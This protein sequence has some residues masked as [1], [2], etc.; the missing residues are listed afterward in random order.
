MCSYYCILS[1]DIFQIKA[2]EF[3]SSKPSIISGVTNREIK[4]KIF[5]IAEIDT[6]SFLCK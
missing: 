5:H 1:R 4:S 6:L 3:D 2:N